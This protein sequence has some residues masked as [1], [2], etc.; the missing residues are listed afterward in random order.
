MSGKT[1]EKDAPENFEV[2]GCQDSKC[3]NEGRSSRSP[4]AIPEGYIET[5]RIG[6][7]HGLEGLMR[8]DSGNSTDNL[9]KASDIVLRDRNGKAFFAEIEKIAEKG[10][11]RFVKFKSYGSRES[12]QPIA[13][14]VLFVKREDARA[15]GEGETY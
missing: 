2:Q 1:I 8:L 13:G 4:H 11:G 14:S 12:A 3:S 7:A 6:K 5:G 9:L 10:D 15:L